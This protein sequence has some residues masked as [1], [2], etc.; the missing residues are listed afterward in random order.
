MP[1]LATQKFS[2]KQAL[3]LIVGEL[4]TTKLAHTDNRLGQMLAN[5]SSD[6]ERLNDLYLLALSR[7]PGEDAAQ[8]LL[9]HVATSQDKRQAWEDVLWTVLNSQE[10]IYQH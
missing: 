5:K 2:R 8:E 4:V 3:E 10:F 9:A 7:T 6:A 1:E